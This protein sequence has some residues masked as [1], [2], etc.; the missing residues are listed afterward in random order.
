MARDLNNYDEF[1]AFLAEAMEPIALICAD[2]EIAAVFRSSGRAV[3]AVAKICSQ[4]SG[5]IA[6]VLAAYDGVTV[7]EFKAAFS[8]IALFSRVRGLIESDAIK[9]LFASAQSRAGASASASVPG[10]MA[11]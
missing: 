4:H 10:N 1:M 8:P 6:A 11:V 7:E 2:A 9:Q 3:D 5:E